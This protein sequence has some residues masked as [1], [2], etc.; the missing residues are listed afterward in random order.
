M[1]LQ[2]VLTALRN[3]DAAGDVDAARRLAQI[4]KRLQTSAPSMDAEDTR[5]QQ[6]LDELRAQKEKPETTFGGNVKEAFK[7]VVPGAVGLLETA[8]TGIAAMLPDDTEKAAREKIKEIAGVAKKPFEAAAG[9][10]DSVGRRL[11]EGL[12]STLPFFGLGPLGLAGRAAGAGLGIAAGAGEAR[13]S[14]EAKGVTGAERRM[15]TLLGAPTGLLDILAPEIGPMKSIITT[16]LARG[17]VEG[18]T[19]AAQKL[20]QNLIAK[21]VYDPNQ[22]VLAGTGEEGAYG[23]G[24]GAMASLILDLTLGRKAR[25]AK[26]GE[27]PEAP[28]TTEA[29]TAEQQLLGY[30]PEPFTPVALPD[31][32]VITSKAEYDQYIKSK[33]GAAAQRKEDL[34]TSDP[35]AGLSEFDRTLARRGKEAALAETFAQEPEKGQLDLPGVERA[36]GTVEVPGRG[37]VTPKEAAAE[38]LAADEVPSVEEQLGLDL[39]GGMT[40]DD[41]INEMYA[42][43]ARKAEKAKAEKERLKFESDLAELDGRIKA[44]EE[45]TTQDKRLELLLPIV[46]S[47][48]GNIPKAFVQTLKREGFTNPNLTER[49]QNLIKRAYD[50]RLMEEPV[51]PEEPT[52]EQPK[53]QTEELEAQVPEKKVQREPEQMGFPGMGKPKGKA[54]EAFSEEE[55]AGQEAPFTGRSGEAPRSHT[56]TEPFVTTLTAEVLDKTGLP[57]QSGF[58]KQLLNLDMAD[59]ANWPVMREVFGRVRTNANVKPATKQAIERMAMQAF[60]GMAKQQELFPTE[61]KGA[62]K[63]A[64]EKPSEPSRGRGEKSGTDGGATGTRTA[65]REP[66]VQKP[67]AAERPAGA[68]PTEKP[69]SA[70]LGDRGQPVRDA[71]KREKVE[72]GALKETKTTYR[73]TYDGKPATVT[74]T[75]T[76]EDP[77]KID[78]VSI[79]VDGARLADVN[80]G[81][82]GVVSDEKMLDNLLE[83]DIIESKSEPK[84]KTKTNEAWEMLQRAEEAQRKADEA[85]KPKAETKKAAPKGDF[86]AYSSM[87]EQN[88]ERALEDL[89][90][91]IFVAT[92]PQRDVAKGLN[93]ITAALVRGEM[94]D[95]KFGREG[96]GDFYPG[97]GGK[98]ARAYYNSLNDA[99]KAKILQQLERFFI[100]EESMTRRGMGWF[101]AKQVLDRETRIQMDE[102]AELT[103]D[104]VRVS[105]PLHPRVV[106]ALKAGDVSAALN[107]F[108]GNMTSRSAKIARALAKAIGGVKVQIVD[109]LKSPS[110]RSLAGSYDATTNTIK[111]D[112]KFGL[113]PHAL[114][115]EATHA[116]V[117][118]VLGNKGHAATKQLTDLFNT[119]KDSL[120]SAYGAKSL[121]EFVS[122]VFSNPEFQQTLAQINPKGEPISALRRFIRAVGNF[123]RNVM[124][125]P[126]KGIDSA[127]DSADVAIMQ[128]VSPNNAPVGSMY[129]AS[130]LGASKDVFKAM[131][132]QV[133]SMP[134]MDN[135]V[136]GG[137]YEVL[138]EKIPNL[139][140]TTILRSLPLNALT[141]VAAKVIP[142]AKK[143]DT[144]EKQWGGAIDE[145]RRAVDATYSNISKWTK[146]NPE[147]ESALN[148]LVMQ[149]TLEEVDPSKARDSYKGKSTKSDK[150]KQA[151]WDSLQAKW[152]AL[153]PEGQAIYK[154][155][156]DAYAESHE[157]L[158]NLLFSRI[159]S[160]VKDP[161]EAE[162]LRKE[163]YQ[164]LAV[165]GKIEPYFPLMRQGDHWVTF[166]AKNADGQ[167]EY[168]KVAFQ[169]SVEQARA[170]RELKA[171]PNVDVKSVQ[172]S[173]P[174]GKRTYRDAP[175]TSFVNSII[176]VLDAN[177]VDPTV[178]DEIMRVFLDTLPESSF[179]QSFRSRLGTLGAMTD[180]A[181]VFYSKS[182]SMAHQLANLEYGAKMYKLRDEMQ[183]YVDTKDRTEEARMLFDTMDRHI[184]SMVSPDISPFAKLTT[185]TA[186]GW[187]LGFNVSS[188]LVNTTQL[189]MVV[190]PYLGGKY[191]Y[192]DANKAIGAATRLFF[193]SGRKRKAKTV[194]G[195]DPVELT[196]G[197]SIDNYDF[198]AL[199]KKKDLTDNEKAILDLR[200]LAELSSQ[201]GLLSRS[202]TSDVLESGAADGP[203]AKINA[204]SGFVFHHGERMNRQVSMVAAY[205]LELE[206]MRKANGGKELTAQDRTAA[207]EEAIR[208]A[209]LLNGGASAN[210]A[211]LLAKNS[212]GKM[213]F[214]YKRYGVSM[215]YMLFKTTHDALIGEDPQ[216]RAA[217]KRQI[218]GIYASTALLA[219]AQGIPMFGLVSALYNLFLKGDDDDDFETAARKYMG[220]GR[221]NGALNYLTGTAVANR[222]GLTDLLLHDTGY[223]DQDNA[224]LS[225]LQLFGG[226]VYGV[227]DRIIRGVKLIFD[228]E[229]LRGLEQVAPAG[230]GNVIKGGRFL[231]EG[232]NTMRGDPIV[233]EVGL[234]HSLAQALGFAP[235]EYMRQ[236]EE[237]AVEKNV[238][239]RTLEKRTNLLRKYYVAL[240]AGDGDAASDYMEELVK[241]GQKHPGL[242]TP[243]VIK[244]SLAQHM[245]TTAT[246]YHGVTFNKL[247]RNELLANAAEFDRDV[248]IF[249][250]DGE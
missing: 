32:S 101:N 133:L 112:S 100:K 16:A 115:H 235:A 106:A 31:G 52:V 23:A 15:A 49:E 43:D 39:Q 74:I 216:V 80:L 174:T 193:G 218:A 89:A 154:Q 28:P 198:D 54:P 137:I 41:L 107:E 246:M 149:S 126:T 139:T 225:F 65:D 77:T 214:M 103:A 29:K 119:V 92:F 197:Y 58:Y 38:E 93:D 36:D 12:G 2:N 64:K 102:D 59:K 44:K 90:H 185:S 150:D 151:V 248:S 211:P 21:G 179:A 167:M 196:A 147:K 117:L 8:G 46:E 53:G 183:E 242:V 194:G 200:E 84:T 69:E 146:G 35:L 123:L 208:S 207:A 79:R 155:M 232:T 11:G 121:D 199:A 228:G 160:S 122:E 14:A 72:P 239:R 205:R 67:A 164:R 124:G 108:A 231:A 245:R 134:V 95:L 145:R 83:T 148:D 82:Q 178:T 113:N 30:T 162:K 161:K 22:P 138:R 25:A 219:G 212:I 120:G 163:I 96:S 175:P 5:I 195:G 152:K 243:T 142:M 75:R 34:R 4:A 221:F 98:Y 224:V 203:L 140:K 40:V 156:R 192:G 181:D 236:L 61:T 229:T 222:I 81:K 24:V 223:R 237:N 116:A 87:Q 9:Y 230:F 6:R 244:N 50:L 159:D 26:P 1:E 70:G 171:D 135:R 27:K 86:G 176:K 129:E 132:A 99:Q 47:D 3:A 78:A 247:M 186:F 180:A 110:G 209:E 177:K 71:G 68:K 131:D 234:G 76:A 57:K 141:D 170:I 158:I 215:Y 238:E 125:M 166:N 130:L 45:R 191:G 165:K 168:Y 13:E 189:P 233:G 144:L 201:Y 157:Q 114:L 20:A 94:P 190:M 10:E 172:K 18:A 105:L 206:R 210:S 19:E 249:D 184:K 202:M 60:G 111:L 226:P 85:A 17:G 48:V 143:L 220:E 55:L 204:W 240:R 182:I 153:G 188:A 127:L 109:D 42:E 63:P 7:G 56:S 104:M 37:R 91:D 128:I 97:T 66:V 62:K 88:P 187:T 217:A 169:N 250:D 51:A 118:K 213:V 33:E 227:G 136:V 73:V 241:L 173:S